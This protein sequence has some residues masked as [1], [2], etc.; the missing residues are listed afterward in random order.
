[1]VITRREFIFLSESELWAQ[2]L[3]AQPQILLK[4]FY[5]RD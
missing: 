4:I 3:G 1:M 5:F 2:I